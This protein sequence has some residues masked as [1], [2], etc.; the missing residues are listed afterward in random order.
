MICG[1]C[2]TYH[3]SVTRLLLDW[4]RHMEKIQAQH[5]GETI[6]SVSDRSA[7]DEIQCVAPW[8]ADLADVRNLPF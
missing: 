7:S 5:H 8:E 4:T 6:G 2:A 1:I 3:D